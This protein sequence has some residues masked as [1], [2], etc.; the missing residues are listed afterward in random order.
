MQPHQRRSEQ[1]TEIQDPALR[2]QRNRHTSKLEGC[3]RRP[4]SN[5]TEAPRN[6]RATWTASIYPI[7]LPRAI[8]RILPTPH[9]ARLLR[10]HR[11]KNLD[12]DNVCPAPLSLPSSDR[13]LANSV[14]GKHKQKEG[15]RNPGPSHLHEAKLSETPTRRSPQWPQR[16][17][18]PRRSPRQEPPRPSQP[19]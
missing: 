6:A 13:P 18:R 10:A 8:R 5:R 19:W 2:I 4:Q 7:H 15:P 1:Q 11:R 12:I 17:R 3:V 16:S 14:A 9:Q